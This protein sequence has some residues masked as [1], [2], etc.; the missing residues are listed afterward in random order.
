[1][2]KTPGFLWCSGFIALNRCVII[3]APAATAADAS[4]YVASV[5]P[6]LK[7]ILRFTTSGIIE[8]MFPTSG[9][10]VNFLMLDKL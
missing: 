10:A 7:M 5:C 9:A 3:F 2:P 8:V 6:M 4:S 1:M